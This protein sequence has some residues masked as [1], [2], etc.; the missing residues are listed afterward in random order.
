[1]ETSSVRSVRARSARISI[2]FTFSCFNYVR[3]ISLTL[4]THATKKS[5]EKQRSNVN[6]T[7]TKTK[8]ALE[9]RYWKNERIGFEFLPGQTEPTVIGAV[10]DG[11]PTPL[12]K[13]Y[14]FFVLL[15]HWCRPVN[16][17]K[18]QQQQQIRSYTSSQDT[19]LS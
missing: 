10:R 1:M 4:L 19:T 13:K 14:V 16:L 6:A 9:H 15:T 18:Q 17:N 7:M 11:C 12:L 5:L 8:L 3:R 2:I